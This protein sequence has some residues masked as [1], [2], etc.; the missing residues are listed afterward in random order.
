MI[1]APVDRKVKGNIP[2]RGSELGRQNANKV[3]VEEGRGDPDVQEIKDQGLGRSASPEVERAVA[4]QIPET[5][6]DC[7]I[8]QASFSVT[9]IEM[10]AAYCDGEVE[11]RRPEA[12]CFQ[13]DR[14]FI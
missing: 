12:D 6:V 14:N 10:H 9:E 2:V 4:P 1:S 8:C 5:S 7:P 3:E 13:G 11:Q